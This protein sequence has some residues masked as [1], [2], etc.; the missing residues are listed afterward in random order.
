VTPRPTPSPTASP[1]P[2]P[3]PTA[4]PTPT[5]TP[6]PSPTASATGSKTYTVKSGDTLTGIASRFG[7]TSRILMD[8]NSI[9]NANLIKIGQILKLP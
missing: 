4:S 2:S 5:P 9:T 6:T 8:L 7:T 1:T 3:R